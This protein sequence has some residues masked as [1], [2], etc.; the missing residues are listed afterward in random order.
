[1]SRLRLSVPR[2][3][4]PRSA[5]GSVD[6]IVEF[7]RMFPKLLK[8]WPILGFF[9]EMIRDC[10]CFSF[11]YGLALGGLACAEGRAGFVVE[12]MPI[13]ASL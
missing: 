8:R 12:T 11:I 10:S 2:T 6:T 4:F 3:V 1:M 5:Q 9:L 13:V 7:H